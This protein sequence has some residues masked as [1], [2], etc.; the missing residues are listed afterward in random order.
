[1]Q[2]FFFTMEKVSH[3]AFDEFYSTQNSGIKFD[4]EIIACTQKPL[5][6][7][8]NATVSWKIQAICNYNKKLGLTKLTPLLRLGDSKKFPTSGVTVVTQS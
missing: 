3:M 8:V 7:L 2:K 6:F 1:M 4:P 5:S